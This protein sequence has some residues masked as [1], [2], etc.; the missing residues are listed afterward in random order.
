MKRKSV[1]VFAMALCMVLSFVPTMSVSATGNNEVV[2][3][4]EQAEV[5]ENIDTVENESP[6]PEEVN[7]ELLVQSQEPIPEVEDEHPVVESITT[8]YTDETSGM[9]CL[10]AIVPDNFGMSVYAQVENVDT[11]VVYNLPM[12]AENGYFERCYVPEGNYAFQIVAVY[13]DNKNEYS[14]DFPMNQF[15]VEAK[16]SAE[17]ELNLNNFDEINLEIQEKRGEIVVDN[18]VHVSSDYEVEHEGTGLGEIGVTGETYGEYYYMI[19]VTQSGGLGI[20]MFTYSEDMGTTWSEP[21]KIP[22]SGYYK[23]GDW[24]ELTAEFFL[25]QIEDKEVSFAEGDMY[26]FFVQDPNTEIVVTQKAHSQASPS[27]ISTTPN[28]RAFEALESSGMHF[29]VKILKGGRFDEAVWQISTDDGLTW[30]EEEYA[31]KEVPFVVPA[32]ENTPELSFILYFED[33]TSNDKT[34]IFMKD[35]VFEIYAERTKDNS[36]VLGI[37]ALCLIVAAIG[38]AGFVGYTYLKKQIPS[39]DCYRIKK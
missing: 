37:V 38:G 3:T 26:S 15:F 18:T 34:E 16:G 4:E 11:G 10:T 9:I 12:Y 21:E 5:D 2:Q 19:K 39:E 32:T 35:D 14:F 24:D 6:Q 36:T 17:Y 13:G 28:M 8:S 7:H 22:L 20:A 33:L 25:P 1:K 31:K 27:I 23:F 29:K 30:N